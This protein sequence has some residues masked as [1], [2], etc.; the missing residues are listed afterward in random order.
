MLALSG[1]MGVG[2][3]L[4]RDLKSKVEE[5]LKAMAE[6]KLHVAENYVNHTDLA[7][8]M[9]GIKEVMSGMSRQI[10]NLSDDFKQF[11]IR[12]YDKLDSKQDKA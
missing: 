8:A 10:F 1:A 2:W 12:V 11:T 5:S 3:Y 9:N 4:Y 6:H 7:D